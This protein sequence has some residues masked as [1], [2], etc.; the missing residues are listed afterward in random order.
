MRPSVR[1]VCWRGFMATMKLKHGQ[2]T[3]MNRNWTCRRGGGSIS[4]ALM[5]IITGNEGRSVGSETP[6]IIIVNV[7]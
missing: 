7:I 1:I 5:M 3:G 2:S 4:V 6:V